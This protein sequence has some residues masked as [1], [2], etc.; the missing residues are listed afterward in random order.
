MRPNR[1]FVIQPFAAKHSEAFYQLVLAACADMSGQFEPFRADAAPS[2]AGTRL[3]DRIDSYIKDADL[4]IADLTGSRSENALLEVGA[5]Y[6]LGLPVIPVSDKKLPTDIS[7][8][9]YIPLSTDQLDKEEVMSR[10]RKELQTHLRELRSHRTAT[11]HGPHFIVHGYASRRAVDF[12]DLT[13]RCEE[14]FDLLTT[15]L[16]FVVN[17]ELPCGF[18]EQP[19]TL[20]DMIESALPDKP[21][22]FTMR[23]LTLDPDSNFTN[24]RASALER[25]RREF[26]DHM[27][28]DL[29]ILK[30][31][32]Q[33]DQC[34]RKVQVKTY[35]DFPLQMTYFFDDVVVSS[36]VANS[37]S[38]RECV[39][40]SHS[41]NEIGARE[42]YERHFDKIWNK[43]A[44]IY[45]QSNKSTPRR[46][47]RQTIPIKQPAV[48]GA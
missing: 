33:S 3:Q 31:F 29:E 2:T 26:R 18:N 22:R 30:D 6:T 39:T 46:R 20:L 23:I 5:A 28:Q 37:R 8:Q 24:E 45:A 19:R 14:R 42:T 25:D 13:R 16:G 48:A 35:D 36:V 1:V 9:L 17:E 44:N 7:N 27:R 43:V 4:C 21:E 38:S 47:T 15:N 32:V 40:Y 10:F 34:N 11:S 12:W 41:L